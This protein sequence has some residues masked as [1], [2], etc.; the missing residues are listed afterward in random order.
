M[1][2]QKQVK[3]EKFDST[4]SVLAEHPKALCPE[5]L[6]PPRSD[7]STLPLPVAECLLPKG[8]QRLGWGDAQH[9]AESAGVRDQLCGRNARQSFWHYP[10]DDVA[11]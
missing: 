1:L 11:D 3:P 5:L 4:V 8:Q 6:H 7:R 2:T 9:T 10:G